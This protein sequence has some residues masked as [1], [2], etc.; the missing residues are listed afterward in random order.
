[1]LQWRGGVRETREGFRCSAGLRR[2][3]SSRGGPLADSV[4]S[5]RERYD[6]WSM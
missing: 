5:I 4:Q 3:Q 1:M 2:A 6:Y